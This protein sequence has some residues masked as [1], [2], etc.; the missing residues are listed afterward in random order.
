VS[1]YAAAEE[2]AVVVVAVT[3]A[4][5]ALEGHTS[6]QENERVTLAESRIP[7]FYVVPADGRRLVGSFQLT[8]YSQWS[9][10]TPCLTDY[11]E[12]VHSQVRSVVDSD[13]NTR[14]YSYQLDGSAAVADGV[15]D[16][17]AGLGFGREP[18]P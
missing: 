17:V 15:V 9:G 5:G 13:G 16:A 6:C 7:C 4:F 3:F 11:Y 1:T 18:D 14:R 2:W 10:E 8:R 12:H